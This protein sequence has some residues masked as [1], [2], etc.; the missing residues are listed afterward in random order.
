M[1]VGQVV[2]LRWAFPQRTPRGEVVV[3][4]EH[5]GMR[6]VG[7]LGVWDGRRGAGGIG[8]PGRGRRVVW[9]VA[10]RRGVG[11]WRHGLGG[12]G[13]GGARLHH[14]LLVLGELEWDLHHAGWQGED[15]VAHHLW[16]VL[17]LPL[18]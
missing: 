15:G 14:G 8:A 5:V 1:V 12:V 11:V 7:R 3:L 17:L 9:R 13:I 10:G 16:H 4:H 2:V 6:H 18:S